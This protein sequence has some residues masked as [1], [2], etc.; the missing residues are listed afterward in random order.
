[1]TV[2]GL[3][4]GDFCSCD[5]VNGLARSAAWRRE[6]NRVAGAVKTAQCR[7]LAST[8]RWKTYRMSNGPN[9]SNIY[10]YKHFDEFGTL[11]YA[12]ISTS[13]AGKLSVKMDES[14]WNGYVCNINICKF[15]SMREAELALSVA[16]ETENPLWKDKATA[17]PVAAAKLRIKLEAHNAL[18]YC[19]LPKRFRKKFVESFRFHLNDDN[20]ICEGWSGW[21]KE[22][23]FEIVELLTPPGDIDISISAV[24]QECLLAEQQRYREEQNRVPRAHAKAKALLA[25]QG[26]VFDTTQTTRILEAQDLVLTPETMVVL[27]AYA[28][29]LP[30]RFRS[31]VGNLLLNDSTDLD[32]AIRQAQTQLETALIK[33]ANV[34]GSLKKNCIGRKLPE[35]TMQNPHTEA[36]SEFL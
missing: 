1:M 22:R 24:S 2:D 34:L 11:L 7:G 5:S 17:G 20:A 10:L 27:N 19:S 13:A 25:K 9:T 3:E 21:D 33:R 30:G 8:S 36:A 12:G 16:I 14:G 15:D 4:N 6:I 29:R 35:D 18:Y 31:T 28:A 23:N 32:Q 26:I